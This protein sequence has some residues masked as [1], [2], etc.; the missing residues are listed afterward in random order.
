MSFYRF[1]SHE[2]TLECRDPKNLVV[3]LLWHILMVYID[4]ITVMDE[5]DIGASLLRVAYEGYYWLKRREV[6]VII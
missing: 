4:G 5:L 2:A 3:R 6:R 1:L